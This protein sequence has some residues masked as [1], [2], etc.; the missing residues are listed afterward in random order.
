MKRIRLESDEEGVPSTTIREIALLKELHHPNIINLR[1]VINADKKLTLIFDYCDFDVKKYTESKHRKVEMIIVKRM[2]FQLMAGIA[3]CHANRVMH[4][5]LKPQN[6]FVTKDLVLK[7]GDFGLARAFGIPVR[8]FTHE[9]VTLWYRPPDVLLG[10]R[11][12]TTAIDVWSCGCILVEMITGRPLFPGS[13]DSDE[14]NRIFKF[15]GYPTVTNW[16]SIVDLPDFKPSIASSSFSSVLGSSSSSSSAS[17]SASSSSAQP[18]SLSLM[19]RCLGSVVPSLDVSGMDLLL[20]M[21][22]YDPSKR[23]TAREAL[24]HPWFS[25]IPA[26]LKSMSMQGL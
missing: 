9:V 22:Q 1:D 7:I 10:N 4:R 19:Q 25:D 3:F 15:L 5:D 18:N 14:L 2:F 6:L 12:Y 21:L 8:S 11:K 16:P 13:S 23:I 17:S 20:K 24:N 26:S